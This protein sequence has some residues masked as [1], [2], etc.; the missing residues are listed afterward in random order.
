MLGCGVLLALG[1]VAVIRWGGL[2]VEPP[3]PEV[4]ATKRYLWSVSVA[5]VGG[6]TAGL[7]VAGAGGR[8]AMRLLAATAGDGAQ[9]RITEAEETVG[10]I[11]VGGTIG[12][13]LFVG[14]FVGL[15]SGG[16]YVLLRRWLPR[17]RWGGLSFG[18]L[19]LVVLAT[20]FEPLR[21]NN[22]DFDVVGPG[23]LALLVFGALAVV[24][25][26]TVA[27]VTARYASN[28]P[29]LDRERRALLRHAP[30]ALLLPL[31]LPALVVLAGFVVFFTA[32]ARVGP[33]LRS[34]QALRAGRGAL[35]GLALVS[36]PGF[37][38]AVADIAGRG[39]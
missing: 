12:F 26:M 18:V 34:P 22:R 6:L 16:L 21:E 7:L 35:A 25:G 8:L 38:G 20:R 37:V 30:L 17:G 29:V 13:V 19:L 23:W 28:Q 3:G 32:E 1:L 39:P 27:A 5:L 33:W 2:D 24:H 31:A 15:L 14:I 4:P 11:T 36:L 9:G 10:R